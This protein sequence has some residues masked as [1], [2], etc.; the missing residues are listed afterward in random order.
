MR[1]WNRFQQRSLLQRNQGLRRLDS[2]STHWVAQQVSSTEYTRQNICCLS[3]S[4]ATSSRVGSPGPVSSRSS[5]LIQAN[6]SSHTLKQCP[7]RAPPWLMQRNDGAPHPKAQIRTHNVWQKE[8]FRSLNLQR[9]GMQLIVALCCATS[10]ARCKL[11]R[12]PR[13]Q[14][15]RGS[16]ARHFSPMTCHKRVQTS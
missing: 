15:I 16:N 14:K 12:P 10:K 4:R 11:G 13:W 8:Y 9:D 7:T 1:R 3:Q 6:F 2:I 5:E